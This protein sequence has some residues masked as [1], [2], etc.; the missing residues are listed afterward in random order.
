MAN[1]S[2][3]KQEACELAT[4]YQGTHMHGYFYV[5]IFSVYE[6]M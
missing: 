2:P 4:S 1:R 6:Y 5:N 3:A